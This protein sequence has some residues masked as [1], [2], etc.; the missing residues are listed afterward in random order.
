M[1][2][3]CALAILAAV[4]IWLMGGKPPRKRR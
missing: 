4:F 2:V 1:D 3:I